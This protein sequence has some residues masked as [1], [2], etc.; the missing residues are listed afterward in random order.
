MGYERKS[1]YYNNLYSENSDTSD[2]HKRPKRS[3]YY[4]LWNRILKHINKDEDRIS[5]FGCGPGQFAQLALRRGYDYRY[6]IDFS[7]VA[8]EMAQRRNKKYK[9]RFD[10]GDLNRATTYLDMDYNTAVF[11]EVLEHI[12]GDME[13]L[14]NIPLGTKVIITLPTFDS[15]GHVRHFKTKKEIRKRYGHIL[16]ISAID[17]VIVNE[18]KIFVIVGHITRHDPAAVQAMVSKIMIPQTNKAFEGDSIDGYAF[19]AWARVKTGLDPSALLNIIDTKNWGL[20]AEYSILGT[21]MA[22]DTVYTYSCFPMFGL[23]RS[24]SDDSVTADVITALDDIGTHENGMMRYCNNP[25]LEYIVPNVTPL[26]ALMYMDSGRTDTVYKLITSL[27]CEQTEGGNWAYYYPHVDDMD[28]DDDGDNNKDNDNK[29]RAERVEDSMHLAMMIFAIR[30]IR[31]ACYD[32]DL[33]DML[34]RALKRLYI[35]NR[36]RVQPG[37]LGWGPPWVLLAVMGMNKDLEI[38]AYND[39]LKSLWSPN[40]RVRAMSAWALTMYYSGYERRYD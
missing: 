28:E 35:M 30:C 15:R 27:I 24:M 32:L 39:T 37:K 6:G 5:D 16:T 31:S 38:K 21:T 18:A 17:E 3:R 10:V 4:P 23:Y 1:R 40:F 33:N 2:Y 22:A 11:S 12:K 36:R 7:R 14:G 20:N 8:I 9:D 26:A 13:L 29:K 25:E 34:R 19:L